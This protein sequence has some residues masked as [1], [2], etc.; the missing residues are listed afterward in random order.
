MII[1]IDVL[2]CSSTIITALAKGAAEV[3]P[4]RTV[5]EAK[6]ISEANPNFILAGERE[7]L[8][9]LGFEFGNSPS[10]M[11]RSNLEG[12]HIIL[13]TTNGTVALSQTKGAKHV[14]IGAFLNAKAVARLAYS[15]AL[16]DGTGITLAMSGTKGS[17]SLED[18]L[19]AGAI[20]ESFTSEVNLSDAPQAAALTFRAARQ[21]V[22]E[23]IVWGSH[24]KHLINIG[25]DEDVT[26]CCRLN[27]YT[28]VPH[29]ECGRI[30]VLQ[31]T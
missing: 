8:M 2:R 12:A 10:T 18:Y 31:I 13:T 27:R 5:K 29:L 24:A 9:P 30:T 3:I 16:K 23:A 7:G 20:V 1:I 26:F 14:L 19:G 4:V 22:L 28:I 17:F 11:N 6:A 21:S 25:F 15:F